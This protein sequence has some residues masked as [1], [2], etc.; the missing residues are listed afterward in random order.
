MLCDLTGLFKSMS[1]SSQPIAPNSVVGRLKGIARHMKLGRQEDAHEFLRYFIDSLQKSALSGMP[2]DC[3]TDNELKQTSLIYSIFGGRL[4]SSITCSRCSHKSTTNDPFLDI[5]LDIKNSESILDSLNL[6]C[7]H[8]LLSKGNRYRCE[9][10][11][12]LSEASKQML[13]DQLPPVITFHLKRFSASGVSC[14]PVLSFGK[15]NKHVDFPCELDMSSYCTTLN[16]P[17]NTKYRLYGVLVHEGH[18]THS[19]HY[20]AFIRASNSMWYCMNDESVTQVSINT[21]LKQKAYILFYQQIVSSKQQD[22]EAVQEDFTETIN[23]EEC[24]ETSSTMP[25]SNTMWHMTCSSNTTTTTP[26]N[27]NANANTGKRKKKKQKELLMEKKYKWHIS[28]T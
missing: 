13:L 26:T 27:T 11:G 24:S 9:S 25:C 14:H 17:R 15:L 7:K 20:Y 4:R 6:F 8:E 16:S 23:L 18:S 19:G 12:E 28:H 5:S 3:G 10:C 22:S 2:I 21:V 1:S